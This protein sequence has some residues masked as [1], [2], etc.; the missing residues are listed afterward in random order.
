MQAWGIGKIIRSL[1]FE[2]LQGYTLASLF[3]TLIIIRLWG[4]TIGNATSD[5]FK[6]LCKVSR[7]T[8]YRA[9][10][11]P[12]IDWRLF[13][14]KITLRFHAIL[15]EHQVDTS[16]NETCAIL[17]DTT[18]QKSGIRIEGVSKVFDHVS[19]SFIYGMKCLTL[20]LS[21]GISC[22]P[23]DFSLHREKGRN[24][25]YG[26]TRKLKKEQHKEKRNL[27]NPDY[28]RK[29]ECDESKLEMAKRMLRHAVKHGISFKYVLADSWFTCE[30]LI[31]AVRELSGGE[32][33]YIGLVKLNPQLRYLT[34]G[35]KRPQNVH[36][37]ITK[38][39]R[40]SS[41]YCRAYKCHY[42]QLNVKFGG[43]SVR[44]FIIKYGRRTNWKVLLTTDTSMHFTKAFEL[45][46]R[47]WGI[48]VIFKECRGYLGL[49]KCEP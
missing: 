36:E 45:Y 34:N 12:R 1:K 15:R 28:A 19:H 26:L 23:I 44:I 48:E 38:Y 29:A 27:R 13:L 47:R 8:F 17:D 2:K 41:H 7:N 39:E 24:N 16:K 43:E 14:T 31:R 49:G 5:H 9:L 35:S 21:D 6:G 46:Q 3:I 11:N 4:K 42:I 37:L 10:L 18:F 33:H 20:A 25:D 32:T 40:N 22:Y 30:S